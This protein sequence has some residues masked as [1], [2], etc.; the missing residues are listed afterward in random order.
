[1][2]RKQP[3]KVGKDKKRVWDG[4]GKRQ[5]GKESNER[6]NKG[7]RRGEKR[8][9]STNIPTQTVSNCVRALSQSDC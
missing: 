7:G 1:M 4:V 2:K 6:Y 9:A 3:N 8:S 5:A